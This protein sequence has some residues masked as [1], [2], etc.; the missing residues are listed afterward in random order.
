MAR[1]R[2]TSAGCLLE[3]SSGEW[4]Y[5]RFAEERT[6]LLKRLALLLVA[7]LLLVGCSGKKVALPGLTVE[8]GKDGSVTVETKDGSIEVSSSDGGGTVKIPE[9]FPHKLMDG[10]K[11]ESAMK[12]TADGKTGYTLALNYT[13]KEVKQ[14]ADFYE[15]ELKALGVTTSRTEM[16]D[17]QSGATVFITGDSDKLGAWVSITEDLEAKQVVVALIYGQK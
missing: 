6:H 11:A 2:H 5:I 17:G 13:G 7:C 10:Y 9:G 12:T 4:T 14:I 8:E 15:A 3:R 1:G 16:T